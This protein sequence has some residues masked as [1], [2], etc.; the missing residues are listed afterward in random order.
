MTRITCR[1]ASP[2]SSTCAGRASTC[3]PRARPRS[4]R[5]T[6]R[7]GACSTSSATW[8]WPAACRLAC[9]SRAATV[10]RPAASCRPMAIAAPSTRRPKAPFRG[11]GCGVVVLKRLAD[12]QRD[13]DVVHAIIRGS[14]INNDGSDK[15]GYTAP[16]VRGQA[17]AIALAYATAQVD[18]ASVGYVEAHGTGTR[19]WRSDRDPRADHG[20]RRAHGAARVLRD[21]IAQ[22]QRRPH[23]RRRRRRRVDQ[24]GTGRRSTASCRRAFISPRPIRRSTSPAARSG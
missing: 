24:G 5:C 19:A 8:R 22:V 15:V 23:G 21:R 10:S 14:A 6:R 3:R 17:E 4:S 13:G 16:S 7:A 12:A 18:P 2:T 9:R 1:R 20:L 11:S